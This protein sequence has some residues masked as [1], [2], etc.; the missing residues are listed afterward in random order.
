MA[1]ARVWS[2]GE[3]DWLRKNISYYPDKGVFYNRVTQKF[4]TG[5]TP[6]TR[7][8][9]VTNLIDGRGFTYLGH[10][11]AWFLH[12]GEQTKFLIDHINRD[13]S[14][15]RIVNLRECSIIQNNANRKPK[16]GYLKGVRT[17]SMYEAVCKGKVI[18]L[19]KCKIKAAAA[20][21]QAALKE[22]GEFAYTNKQHGV[23]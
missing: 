18:G 15:N 5:P 8:V 19:F 11:L 7:Y 6:S 16:S 17:V 1:K 3:E 14:D 20:Y 12:Y 22:F 13:A 9:R 4:I 21:D 2:K 23:Y 10:R